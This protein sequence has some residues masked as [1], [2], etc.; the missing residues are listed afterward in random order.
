MKKQFKVE[1][2]HIGKRVDQ[3]VQT[4]MYPEQSR[5]YVQRLIK[6]G[7]CLVNNETI[8]TG[9]MLKMGDIITIDEKPV[10][11]LDLTAVDLNLEIVYED[12]DLVVI[13]KPQGLVVH[14]A[15][16][17]HEPTL[18]HGLLHQV[19]ELS[20]INGIVRPGIVHRIDKDTS[21][22]LVVAKNDE[23]HRYL[24]SELVSHAIKREYL[25]LV[26][27]DFSESEGS[28]DA[29]ISRHPSNRLKMAVMSTGKHAKT[30]FKV[31][32]RF[33]TYTLV[34]CQLETGR[35]HQIRVHMA[36]IHHPVVGDPLYGPKQVIGDR[37][38]Y[39]HAE[40]LTLMHPTKKEQM[41]F[42]AKLPQNFEDFLVELRKNS[43]S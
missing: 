40:R 27:G 28:I 3:V 41:T 9:Y 30:Y 14:P 42:Y 11:E 17:Y 7:Q 15:S 10:Q 26:Y 22:L 2:E 43:A 4:A 20:S 12:E 34:Q 25:A 37:G 24:S 21:G 1:T 16:S 19:D 13:N 36:F 6:D 23:S 33:G 38:Q 32:E 8:K 35:T 5:S 31:L 29:P 18:V 39:L